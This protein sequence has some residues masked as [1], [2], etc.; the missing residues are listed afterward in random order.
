MEE[1]SKSRS[2]H[3]SNPDHPTSTSE[4]HP[5]PSSNDAANKRRRGLGVVTPNAC[6]ECRKKRAKCDGQRPCG[7]CRAQK[8]VDCVYEIP[9]RQSKENLRSEI[10]QLRRQQRQHDS[11]FSAL[12]RPELWE[13][14]LT[15]MRGGQSVESISEWLGSGGGNA[16]SQQQSNNFGQSLLPPPQQHPPPKQGG[17]DHRLTLPPLAGMGGYGAPGPGPGSFAP[18]SNAGGANQNQQAKQEYDHNSPWAFSS[19]D[20]SHSTRSNSHPDVMQWTADMAPH[21]R[22]GSWLQTQTQQQQSPVEGVRHHGVDQIFAPIQ[23]PE[24]KVPPDTWTNVT[25]DTN[26]VQHLLALYFCW[27]YPTFASLSK[28][29]FLKDFLDGRHRY[30]SP[31]LVNALL[32]LGCRFSTQPNTRENPDDPYTSGDHFFKEALRLMYRESN[33]HTLMTIQALGIMS[34]REA[35]CGRDSES[36][37]Y[38]GQSVRLALEMGLHKVDE[39]GDEDEMAVQA[40]TFWGAF[41]LDHAWSLATGSLP[42]CSCFPSLPP[43]PAII[44]DI[45]SSLWVP[46]TD[47]GAPL[48]R[49]CEQPSNVRSVY[50][51]FCELS[52]LVHQSLYVLHSPGRPVT[53]RDLLNIYTQYLNWYDR[54]PEVLRLGHNFTPAVLFAHMYYH[55]AILLLFRPLIKLRIIGSS[56][57]P[58]DV[59]SQAADAI[60]GLLRSYSQ[61]YTLRRT[62]SFV[63]YFV[64]TSSI[65]HLA[66]GASSPMQSSG[67]SPAAA[68]T[69]TAKPEGGSSDLPHGHPSS[70]RPKSSNSSNAG[71]GDGEGTSP[72]QSTSS[73]TATLSP[74]VAESLRQGIADLEEM[75]PCHHFAEQALHI[76]RYLARKWHI[77]INLSP[78]SKNGGLSH[79]EVDKLVGPQTSSLNFFTPK[80]VENDFICAW[81][82]PGDY[83][84]ENAGGAD[85][86]GQGERGEGVSKEKGAS[87]SQKQIFR[88]TGRGRSG[89]HAAEEGGVEA[90]EGEDATVG[91]ADALDRLKETVGPGNVAPSA[92][93]IEGMENPLFWPFPMQGRPI[94]ASGP[95]LRE[96]GFAPL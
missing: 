80:V 64:L 81:G 93:S 72:A 70:A 39:N 43:K 71:G 37:Y 66:I 19:Q 8:D 58:R 89:E 61:L 74:K 47:D 16:M 1:G 4:K 63:P 35:S 84:D 32:A 30:C 44:N 57:L 86:D 95:K 36:W 51:C 54:I 38:A 18:M 7:R 41:A 22:V 10:D 40:A 17:S 15:R 3:S 6:T 31:I 85:G 21:T 5:A 59:C 76:L 78:S 13:E 77:D 28:E 42:Q 90:M 75:A 11:V 27:E 49:S 33:H 92:K 68:S 52:E 23:S 91:E 69:P 2:G 60:Q 34:I 62:P 45:E 50:K 53:S 56:I 25:T 87:E 65:M 9:V 79:A 48:Q 55:F 88:A 94:L 46:Y 20:Q 82:T 83:D 67:A 26:L 14:V 12:V 29:H 73:S 24:M 96:A